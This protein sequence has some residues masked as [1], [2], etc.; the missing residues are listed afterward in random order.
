[1]PDDLAYVRAQLS[2]D[3]DALFEARDEAP[4]EATA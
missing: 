2:H 4:A 3:Y 1:V